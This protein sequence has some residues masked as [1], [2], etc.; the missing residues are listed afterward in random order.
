MCVLMCLKGDDPSAAGVA[1]SSGA[2]G[3]GGSSQRPI[4]QAG[5]GQALSFLQMK[6]KQLC[7]IPRCSEEKT[8]K[9]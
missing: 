8:R 5:G 6:E 1:Q 2:A 4:Q 3:D 9:A 7:K